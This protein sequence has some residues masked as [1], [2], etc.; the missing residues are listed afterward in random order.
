MREREDGICV[1]MYH[2]VLEVVREDGRCERCEDVEGIRQFVNAAQQHAMLLHHLK[3][4]VQLTY[5]RSFM[6]N[7]LL[8]LGAHAQRGLRYLVCVC[9][10]LSL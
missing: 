1:S 8:T 9:V 7:I 6:S 2:Q 5:L 3:R 4:S 10:C